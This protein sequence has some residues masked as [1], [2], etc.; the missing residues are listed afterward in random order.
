MPQPLIIL[1]TGGSAYDVLDLIEAAN[2]EKLRW[3]VVGF[4]DDARPPGSFH[5]GFPIL[6][7]LRDAQN[8]PHRFFVNVI[9]SDRNHAMRRQIVNST[10]VGLERFATL[11]HP[12]ASVSSRARLGQ[13]VTVHYGVS[14]A[15]GVNVGNQ[16]S[17]CP[18]SIVGHDCIVEDFALVAPGAVVSGFVRVGE[19]CY[20]GSRAVI[21]QRLRIGEQ[22]LVGMGAVVV[23]DVAA[24]TIVIGNPARAYTPANG[25]AE[26]HKAIE[27][28]RFE[29]GM[30]EEKAT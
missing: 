16:V 23:R 7:G 9:G 5:L 4:L 18:G 12:A 28:S 17:F 10:G 3:Q 30:R 22:A 27:T 1:G 2:A 6:G 19:S 14:I 21:R 29:F 24:R 20:I 13:G 26:H 15:G 25:K 8:F 11:I